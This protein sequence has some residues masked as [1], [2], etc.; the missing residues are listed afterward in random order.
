MTVV[1]EKSVHIRGRVVDPDGN[2]VAGATAAAAL[3]GSGNSL[4]GDDRFSVTTG[5][6]GTFEME[7]PASNGAEYNLMAHDGKYQQWRKWANGTLPPIR[8][9]P[10][11]KI[12]GVDIQLTRPATVRGRVIDER[13][14]PVAYREVRAHAADKL[15]NRYYDPTV[16]T[17]QHGVFELPFIRPGEQYI[18]AAPFLMVAEQGPADARKTVTLEAGQ[19]VE[20][21]ELIGHE[22]R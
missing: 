22:N 12:E 2:P 3:T 21:I 16:K 18:Q 6:D 13:G 15:E 19:T 14:K 11:Q 8:T 20:G 17:N 10:G 5:A 4:T 7:L 9:K 1:L